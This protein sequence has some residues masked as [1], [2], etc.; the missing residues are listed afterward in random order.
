M[1][2]E[3][4]DGETLIA[5]LPGVAVSSGSA[6]SSAKKEP[7]HVLSAIGLTPD[8]AQASVRF[9]LGRG[10]TESEIDSAIEQV[11]A[12]VESLRRENPMYQLAKQG[13][14]AE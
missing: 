10:T 5:R 2:F 12:T 3:H 14:V 1:T 6:C 8:Q 11:V 4:C 13:I 9:G 7:S